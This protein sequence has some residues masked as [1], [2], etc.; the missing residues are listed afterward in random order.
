MAITR[1]IDCLSGAQS[2]LSGIFE[3]IRNVRFAASRGIQ[4]NDRPDVHIQGCVG[5]IGG[6]AL[7]WNLENPA[8][9][10]RGDRLLAAVTDI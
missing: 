4:K 6:L 9:A 8:S 7:K 3:D 5:Y 1:G 10:K 2:T